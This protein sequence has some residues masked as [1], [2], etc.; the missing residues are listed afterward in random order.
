MPRYRIEVREV[1]FHVYEIDTDLT[2]PDRI[3]DFFYDMEDQEEHRLDTEC[4]E[5][6]VNEIEEAKP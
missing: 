5:F 2:D 3:E 6:V 4:F 1:L